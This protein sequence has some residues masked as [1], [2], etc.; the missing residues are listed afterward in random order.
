MEGEGLKGKTMDL[1][2]IKDDHRM[3]AVYYADDVAEAVRKLKE[4]LNKFYEEPTTVSLI[5]LIDECFADVVE[6]EGLKDEF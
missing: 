4:E 2:K 1:D 5:E 3:K 6:K